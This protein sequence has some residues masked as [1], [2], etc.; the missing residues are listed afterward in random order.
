MIDAE[1]TPQFDP[2]QPSQVLTTP[3]EETPTFDP[4]QPSQILGQEK[5]AG[6]FTDLYTGEVNSAVE[7]IKK[8]SK[9]LDEGGGPLQSWTGLQGL[10][11]TVM[12]G[13]RYV[14]SP[15]TAVAEK[16]LGEPTEKAA[17]AA[18][19]SP[20]LASS[21][22]AGAT[23]LPQLA[24]PEL[25]RGEPEPPTLPRGKAAPPA[26]LPRA[27]NEATPRTD[28]YGQ[29][30]S[31]PLLPP[32]VPSAALPVS[33]PAGAQTVSPLEGIDP[34]AVRMVHRQL[35]DQSG[36][37][38]FQLEQRLEDMSPRE[39]AH[40]V[41][42]PLWN[43]AEGI[44][45][46]GGQGGMD[47]I[48]AHKQRNAEAPQR[49]DQILNSGMG[50]TKDLSTLARVDRA[51]QKAASDPLYQDFRNQK[52]YPTPELKDVMQDLQ[53]VPGVFG[54]AKSLARLR[55]EPFDENFFTTGEQKNFPTASSWDLIK[56][57]LD[58]KIQGSFRLQEGS[59]IPR[60]TDF[61]REYVK[62]RNNLVDAID[63]HPDPNVAG[64]WK[65]ARDTFAGPENIRKARL[66]GQRLIND[67]VDL[68][69]VP[70]T[71]ARWGEG[72]MA[73]MRD[74]L[75]KRLDTMQGGTQ[76]TTRTVTKLL[77][78]NVRDK[79]QWAFK[80]EAQPIIDNLEAE[81]RMRNSSSG[82]QG[83]NGNSRT[84]QRQVNRAMWQ[85]PEA[86]SS[87]TV[88]TAMDVGHAILHPT[89]GVPKL[90]IG[91][92]KKWWNKKQ[93]EQ[94]QQ[95]AD[96]A[97]R[98]RDDASKI[99]L[100]Q[101]Q[102]RDTVLPWILEHGE[103]YGIP[104]RGVE[105][106]IPYQRGGAV[107]RPF[108]G[109]VS[110]EPPGV[111]DEDIT[112]VHPHDFGIAAAPVL[113]LAPL[114]PGTSG[115][116][117]MPMGA[118]PIMPPISRPV[119]ELPQSAGMITE[120]RSANEPI[121]EQ[122]PAGGRTVGTGGLEETPRTSTPASDDALRAQATADAETA[123]A[124]RKPLEGLPQEHIAA[125]GYYKPGPIGSLHDIAEQ[126][127]EEAGLPY[128]PPKTYASVDV[129]RAKKI[130]EEYNNMKHDPQD[131]AVQASYNA[132]IDETLAQYQAIK[133]AG[134][135]F[136]FIPPDTPN[137]YE[138]TPRLAAKDI[139]DNKHLWVY[140]TGS[141]FGS[142]ADMAAAVANNP[143][144][145]PVSEY[146]N[147]Q[148][149]T[150]NDVFR[151]VHDVFGHFKDGNGFRAGGEENAWRSHSAMYSDLARPAMTSET[152]GQNS[153]VN[154]GPHGDVNRNASQANTTY[155]DQ[156][157]GLLPEW[158][159]NEGRGDA[160]TVPPKIQQL[161]E[162]TQGLA[163]VLKYATP[164]EIAKIK[165]QNA[166]E[167]GQVFSGFNPEEAAAVSFSARAKRG[168]YR[169][170]AQAIVNTFGMQDAPRFAALLASM[171]P[172][173][174]V[175][176]NATNALNTWVNWVKAGRPVDRAS[177]EKI[178]GKSVQGEGVDSALPAWMNNS[179]ASL[180][181]PQPENLQ[182]SGPKVNSFARNLRG[183]VND[184]TLDAWMA[185]YSNLT[186]EVFSGQ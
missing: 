84:A 14:G 96:R 72:E 2:N 43:G 144:L 34:A 137:P 150:A 65:M 141:G 118:S 181:H 10:G 147:G 131:P 8:G 117:Q 25:L 75:R 170:S 55:K 100:M 59:P 54:I 48:Q 172:Q 134:Y 26:P 20:R 185:N 56:R 5:P 66:L 80:D 156:K 36:F 167:I 1:P 162:S 40:E 45:V 139:N 46:E 127:M 53:N 108:G 101:G 19:A 180:Q 74:G 184:V 63:N 29:S 94:A 136:D 30:L 125:A 99:Y 69:E 7:Q 109:P 143:L 60:A 151:I 12:G 116:G 105:Q 67:N 61:T 52:I 21:L 112:A 79:L 119:E 157:A 148:Q 165:K 138:A 11:N 15:I 28:P 97:E 90:G 78:P 140:P 3:A 93:T 4:K 13:L 33:A 183:H 62:I 159:I 164:D 129:P 168:W 142:D 173:S 161:A 23:A 47:I 32:E 133:K 146:I 58:N 37:T 35:K 38:K 92:A 154:Y 9:Q 85:P 64:K 155:A 89:T 18:G 163:G 71:T 107:S 135:T 103:N 158:A 24:I 110:E 132:M 166:D 123:A 178:I 73:A 113:R 95:A 149:M 49:L 87:D 44:A 39:F 115:H 124:G 153:W 83:I 169:N 176:S 106:P 81:N 186:P 104:V 114:G 160:P 27:V 177:I 174:S 152:R 182:L 126:Y 120:G 76:G 130:A 91:L 51:Q 122:T 31:P 102:M 77:T 175:E 68:D 70:Y 17:L 179:V 88:G 86:L 57:A 145:R 16:V 6:D 128:N 50:A 121:P 171:S 98:I 42:T 82:G 41:S 111:P 22:A